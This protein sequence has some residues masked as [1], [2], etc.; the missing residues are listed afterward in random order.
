M[1][2]SLDNDH[3]GK[4][5]DSLVPSRR[6]LAIILQAELLVSFI[7]LQLLEKLLAKAICYIQHSMSYA[8]QACL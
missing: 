6:D 8:R 1:K 2:V 7:H 3:L 4:S 5:K